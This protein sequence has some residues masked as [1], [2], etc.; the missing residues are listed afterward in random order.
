MNLRQ[1]IANR[2]AATF[3]LDVR[4]LAALRVALGALILVDLGIR[5]TDFAAM[6]TDAGFAPVEMVRELGGRSQMGPPWSLYFL[7]SATG[8]QAALFLGTAAA[9]LALVAG[10][11]TRLATIVAWV[12]V[13][14]LQ[15][16]LPVVINAG[17]TLLRVLLFWGMFL[18]LGAVWS[19]DAKRRSR[20]A[21]R[22]IASMATVAYIVQLAIVYW[23][24]GWAKWNDAWLREDALKDIFAF[25]L[26]R[27]PLAELLARHP[28]VT[29]LLS[30]GVV[31]FELLA[32]LALFLPF[33]IA[34][35][36]MLA[37]AAFMAFHVGIALTVTV[38]LF[39]YVAMAAWLAILPSEFW[40]WLMGAT[41]DERVKKLLPSSTASHPIAVMHSANL[42]A[43]P[44]RS[45]RPFNGAKV[46]A[47]GCCLTALAIMLY[48]NVSTAARLRLPEP[49]H[50]SLKTAAHA[51][52]LRQAWAVFGKPPKQDCW[53]VYQALLK[54]GRRI[55]LLSR[56]LG[57]EHDK[58]SLASQQFANHRWRK[59]HWRLRLPS[60]AAYR[61]P[62]AEYIVRRWNE[63]HK[64]SQHI[65]RLNLYCYRQP[66]HGGS[67]TDAY[68]RESLAEVSTGG[69]GGNFAEAV[70]SLDGI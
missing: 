60:G 4:S 44:R 65:V 59:L 61:Q 48:W 66:L 14:S 62:V 49:A 26:Y 69:E 64:E 2:F 7:S 35:L 18:P 36:R 3:G 23:M 58:P 50:R 25:G 22:R 43:P 20:A 40:N 15:V 42:W 45:A 56:K 8:Y 9:A 54:D 33:Q 21:P 63:T 34:R 5:G 46:L 41:I 67:D 6:Y 47:A 68:T 16:R 11:H 27:L 24:A 12:L 70:R 19:V 57:A 1:S 29:N 55:D 10:F 38:G 37:I 53:Y 32:P 28:E 30:A 39:S 17:D 51:T 31:W 52:M 13:V